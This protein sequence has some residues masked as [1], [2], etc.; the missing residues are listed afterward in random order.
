MLIP[1]SAK[2]DGPSSKAIPHRL[3]F[4]WWDNHVKAWTA[5]CSIELVFSEKVIL[6]FFGIYVSKFVYLGP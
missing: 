2:L 3:V 6:K 1:E 5:L 4:V